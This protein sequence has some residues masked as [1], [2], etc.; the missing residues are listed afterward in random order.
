MRPLIAAGLTLS[1]TL[2]FAAC[3]GD[4]PDAPDGD[5]ASPTAAAQPT[6]APATAVTST[7]GTVT[8]TT[9][10]PA[11]SFD[12][13]EGW[14]AVEDTAAGFVL[15]HIE[16]APPAEQAWIGVFI[17]SDVRNPENFGEAQPIPEDLTA[18]LAANRHL[19][20]VR[21]PTPV[22]LD[23]APASQIDVRTDTNFRPALFG[24]A[25][26]PPEDRIDLNFR[27]YARFIEMQDVEGGTIVIASGAANQAYF[28]EVLPL[29][30]P[31][32]ASIDF[33]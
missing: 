17:A 33:E 27:D 18:W 32:I 4:D 25:G 5:E 28:D 22:T 10:A 14:T 24:L 30:E 11:V 29:I 16:G 19:I 8:S 31:V 7:A 23:G 26:R 2:V 1:L 3:G 12:V 13:P 6:P 9:F 15:E 21:G 20:V